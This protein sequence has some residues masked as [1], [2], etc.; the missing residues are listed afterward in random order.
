MQ[1]C[2]L[3]GPEVIVIAL[4]GYIIFG[5]QRT[6]EAALAA[7]RTL[8]KV[9]RTGWWREFTQMASEIRRL[10]TTLV[11][12]AELE[13]M[14]AELQRDVEGLRDD[15]DDVVPEGE[16]DPWGI[17]NAVSQTRRPEDFQTRDDQTGDAP[18][19]PDAPDASPDND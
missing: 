3:G 2:G 11:R 15:I 13:E 17:G 6:Q 7:G 5:P 10:P 19:P 8:R 4:L 16:S 1:I 18:P 9:M 14:Q 12:L